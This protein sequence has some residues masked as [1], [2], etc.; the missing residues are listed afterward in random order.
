[1]QCVV[2]L[3]MRVFITTSLYARRWWDLKSDTSYLKIQE[4]FPFSLIF[5]LYQILSVL[6]RIFRVV[7]GFYMNLVL[8]IQYI[9]NSVSVAYICIIW[10]V[11]KR[12]LIY[13]RG[14]NSSERWLFPTSVGRTFPTSVGRT[15][16]PVQSLMRIEVHS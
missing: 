6:P 10:E 12:W 1:M 5:R 11:V 7:V 15:L 9:V 2:A 14:V 13:L 3:A 4:C 16:N 8:F